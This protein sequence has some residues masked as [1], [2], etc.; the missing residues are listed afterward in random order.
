MVYAL[1]ARTHHLKSDFRTVTP[2]RLSSHS[3]MVSGAM[4]SKPQWMMS[5]DLINRLR[6]H[7]DKLLA[8]RLAYS[9]ES[10]IR[11]TEQS[12][13]TTSTRLLSWCAEFDSYDL[14]CTA[15]LLFFKRLGRKN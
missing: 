5:W 3:P 7:P 2:T 9:W 13:F 12:R 8:E 1:K 15:R 11:Y 14:I 6:P 4:E 10:D